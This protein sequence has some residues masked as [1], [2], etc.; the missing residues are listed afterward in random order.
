[1]DETKTRTPYIYHKNK[2]WDYENNKWLDFYKDFNY[3][4]E[5]V[6]FGL[7]EISGIGV[8][9]YPNP[10]GGHINLAFDKNIKNGLATIFS[11]D[12]KLISNQN[13]QGDKSH[14]NLGALPKG[15]YILIINIEGEIFSRI[16]VKK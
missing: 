7:N 6:P 9:I 2:I 5:F 1:M 14:F 13:I 16:V 10:T 12:G 3:W 15:K 11:I 8:Q 4:S